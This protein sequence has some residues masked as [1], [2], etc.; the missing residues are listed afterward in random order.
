M[1]LRNRYPTLLDRDV[2]RLRRAIRFVYRDCPELV[3]QAGSEYHRRWRADQR[4]SEAPTPTAP[5]PPLA[6]A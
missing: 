3:R 2:A 4:K 1:K 6:R 5:S